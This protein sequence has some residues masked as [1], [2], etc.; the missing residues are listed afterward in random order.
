MAARG[1]GAGRARTTG[2]T[3]HATKNA[4]S[5]SALTAGT[6]DPTT[7]E[8][9]PRPTVRTSRGTGRWPTRELTTAPVR[10]PRRAVPAEPLRHGRRLLPPAR[11][12]RSTSRPPSSARYL[13]YNRGQAV[14]HRHAATGSSWAAGRRPSAELDRAQARR[15][16]SRSRCPTAAALTRTADG[17]R[18]DVAP[19]GV[20]AAA[21]HRLRGVP[22]DRDRH[23]RPP[24]RRGHR[25]PGGARVRRRPHPRDGLRVPRRRRP[26]RQAVGPVR[27]RRT[28]WST[29]RT[30]PLTGGKGAALEAV[31]SG[32]PTPRPGRLADVQGLAGAAVADP[33]GHLL[34]VARALLAR[35]AADLRQPARRERPAVQA[36]PAQAQLRATTWTSS[37]CRRKRHARSSSTTSTRSTAGPGKGWYRIVTSPWQA[38]KVINEGKLAVIMGIETSVPFGCTFKNAARRRRARLRRRVDRRAARRDA[39]ARRAADGAGQQVR[40]RADRRGRR[41]GA[42]PGVAVNAANFLETGS[43]WDMQHCEPA[44]G[45]AARPAPSSAQPEISG[46]A[47]GRAVRRDRQARP[48]SAT[49]RRCRSTRRPAHCNER[50]LTDLG[51]HLVDRMAEQAHAHRPRPHERQGPAAPARPSSRSCSYPGVLSSHSWSTPD[52]YPRIY[53]LGGYVAPY[54]GDSDGLLREVAAPPR[55]GGQAL[56]LRLRLRRRHERPRRAG[57][58]ARRRRTQPGDLPV[59]RPARRDRRTSSTAASGSTTSTSRACRTTACTPTGSRTSASSA[60]AKDGAA[61]VDDM[62]RGAEAY[63]QTWERAQGIARGR[64]AA[65]RASGSGVATFRVRGDGPGMTTRAGHARGRPALHPARLDVRH[66]RPDRERPPRADDG[67][68][69]VRGA[70]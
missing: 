26:L 2:T 10:D 43:F 15:R 53:R 57:R 11:R 56:L 38:R 62:D 22:R 18:L 21:H 48:T 68:R 8:R 69:S 16:R 45:E 20:R 28:R 44:D 19:H 59:H 36:L 70:G 1:P 40:Q 39:Q 27:R 17:A 29:A 41:R 24:A 60:A 31:L 67:S 55:L 3:T 6:E 13:L 47:A 30:T 46:R 37:A 33:R 35:R 25:H 65:T 49:S 4:I 23:H 50:G 14:P 32:R 58:P 9:A 54:A 34:E 63:L 64:R 66:L 7:A 51:E 61:I 12:R 52:A 5:R 42:R